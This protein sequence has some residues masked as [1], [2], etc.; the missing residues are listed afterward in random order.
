MGL[1]I[2]QSFEEL[3]RGA[4]G[5]EHGAR[6]TALLDTQRYVLNLALWPDGS[7]P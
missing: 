3:R 7:N 5:R 4:A 1:I 2:P 6:A